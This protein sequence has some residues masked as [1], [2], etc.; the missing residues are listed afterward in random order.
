MNN[1]KLIRGFTLV[2]LA[3]V[4]VIIGLIL[5][6]FIGTISSRIEATRI[7]ETKKELED[8]KKAILGYAY[9]KG[10]LPCPDGNGDGESEDPCVG[11]ISGTIPSVTL[12]LGL[13]DAWSNRYEYWIDTAFVVEF[14][15]DTDTAVTDGG[16]INQRDN[17]DLTELV[18]ENAV[19]VIFSKGKNGLGAT[20]VDGV[21]RDAIPGTG[22][23]DENE[24]DGSDEVF[25]SRPPTSE[26][27]ATAGGE[28]DDIVIWISE[29]ELKAKMVEAGK[30]P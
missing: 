15:L 9:K 13:G 23:D 18:A 27:A 14:D 19:A 21:A 28:F 29:F 25:V 8:I 17:S 16:K 6:S 4:L 7:A 12:G 3:M 24:N 22:H 20:G 1:T 30:L 26:D 11:I 10:E 2:E 5:G